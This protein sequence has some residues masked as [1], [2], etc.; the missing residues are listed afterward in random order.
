[1]LSAFVPWHEDEQL[2]L[3]ENSATCSYW[4]FKMCYL[5]RRTACKALDINVVGCE[6]EILDLVLRV[7]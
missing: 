6:H 4:D 2:Q 3:Q 7:D 1:M 5:V